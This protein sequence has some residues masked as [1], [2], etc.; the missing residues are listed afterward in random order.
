ME[1]QDDPNS[2]KELTQLAPPPRQGLRRTT[3][4]ATKPW[5]VIS[6]FGKARV[7]EAGKHHIRR[8]TGIPARDLRILDPALSYPSS[9]LGRERAIVVNLENIKAIITASEML[10]LNP[11]DPSLSPFVSDLEHKL[12]NLDNSNMHSNGTEKSME[13]SPAFLSKNGGTSKVLPF[14]FRV[15]EICLKFVCKCLESEASTLEQE[16]YPAL[17]EL[18]VSVSTLNLQ[19]VRLIKSRLVALSAR[20][21]K[22][23]EYVDD[24]EDYINIIL[25]EKQNQLLQIG[26]V[27]STAIMLLNIGIVIAGIFGMN[28]RMSLF[29]NGVPMQFNMTTFGVIAGILVSERAIVVNLENIK[30]I[31]TASEML[32]LNPRDPSLSPFVSDLEHKLC[33]LDNSNTRSNASTL[34]Q[35]AYPALDELSISVSTL[36]LQRV[37]IIKSRLVALS[38]RIK[39]V[40]DELEYL[41]DDDMDMAEMYLTDKHNKQHA[42]KPEP[43]DDTEDD[44][45]DTNQIFDED[46]GGS[47]SSSA[48]LSGQKPKVEELEM[49]L[50][51]YFAQLEGVL[52]K[53]S[54]MREY[55]DGILGMNIRIPL[56]DYGVPMQFNM[57]TF[58]VFAGIV[59]DS[60][61]DKEFTLAPPPRQ[62]SRRTS[63]IATKPWLVISEFGKSRVEEAGKHHIRRRTGIPARDLRILDPALSYPSSVLGRERAI[64]VNLENIKAIIT[65]SEMLLLN[66]RDPSLSPFVSDLEHKLCNL[67]N[68][69]MRSNCNEGTEKSTEDSPTFLSK[70]DGTSRVLPFEFRVLEICLKFVCKCLESEASTLEQEAYPAL[71]ELSISVST[72]NLQR[73][74]IIK[75]RLVALSA[76]IKKVRDELEYLL[77]DDMDMAEM[78]LTDK[79]NKQHAEKPEPKDDTEDDRQDTNQIFDEDG[80]GSRS[81]SADLSGQKPK[82]EELEMLLEAYFAQLEGALS[83]LSTMREYVDDTEDY[84]NIILDEKQNQLLQIG[85]VISTAIMLLNIGIVIAG[86]FGMNIDTSLSE[87]GVPMQFNMTTFGVCSGIVVLFAVAI[88]SIKKKGL[89][90]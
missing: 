42:E 82:V 61:S 68:S 7:E 2:D 78:Y 66:P 22:M 37:R 11:R 41:L 57:T 35:E 55:V 90:G 53:L 21:Q 72:L 12:C 67:D 87:D 20:V 81:S 9:V 3:N 8:R 63:S 69:N 26:V 5:L 85:V 15:L 47:R 27:M 71:D 43:K 56:F 58:G 84:I 28:I 4:I 30:A 79:H 24:T 10:L 1:D 88:L 14:E 46:G 77:D 64:V 6:A 50:E 13:D 29:D 23:R 89:L 60:N 52:S 73:V 86:I 25:D 74:R 44:R 19:R 39:K 49:L 36:N 76:R 17:D 18:S 59:D 75:S 16:A 51:A 34:E 70:N 33:N 40:R 83:K 62:A 38:A 32:L 48:D 45:Q 54:T 80:G 65:A 31:I